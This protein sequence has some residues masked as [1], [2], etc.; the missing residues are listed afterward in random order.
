LWDIRE[1]L[2]VVSHDL[3]AGYQKQVSALDVV[4]SGFFDS[5]G[6]YQDGDAWQ[7]DQAARG[8]DQMGLS[9]LSQTPFNQLSQ[10]ERQMIL[11]ARAMVKLP[12][13]LL[14]DEP[15]AGLDP[16]NRRM[17]LELVAHIGRGG[18]TALIFVSHHEKE[19]PNCMTH[20]LAL[21]HGS[22]VYRGVIENR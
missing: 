8:L 9:G 3:A 15:C 20:R 17:V 22:V 21:D 18:A 5:I 14:L 2:G 1:K 13:L 11:I 10:G 4:C 6:L 7:I 12:R 16:E 19:I